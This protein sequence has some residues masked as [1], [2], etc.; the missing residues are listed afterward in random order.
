[1]SRGAGSLRINGTRRRRM[2]RTVALGLTW[3]PTQPGRWG[4]C[5]ERSLRSPPCPSE[6]RPFGEGAR[7]G[8]SFRVPWASTQ[9]SGPGSRLSLEGPV[10]RSLSE[11]L[12]AVNTALR[13]DLV[14][15]NSSERLHLITVFLRPAARR[16]V[17]P[18]SP[19]VSCNPSLHVTSELAAP[20]REYT[21]H[22]HA[23]GRQ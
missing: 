18:R 8:L 15:Q 17:P 5:G 22:A 1:M 9:P 7:A 21:F 3:Q 19:V 2:G 11:F 6:D 13:D 16:R 14:C 12:G 23:A 10:G 4:G 20:P